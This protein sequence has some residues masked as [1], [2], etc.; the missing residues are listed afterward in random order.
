M[1]NP[2]NHN[3]FEICRADIAKLEDADL[4]LLVAELCRED[5]KRSQI[6]QTSV[7]DGGHQDAADGGIDI[8]IKVSNDFA[9]SVT[10]KNKLTAIQVKKPK[11]NPAAIK[12]E[13][14]PKGYLRPSLQELIKNN[15][16][17]IIV[18]SGDCVTDSELSKRIIA[19]KMATDNKLDVDFFDNGRLASWVSAY[20][21]MILWVKQKLGQA[22]TGWQAYGN[23]ANQRQK[24]N[25]VYLTDDTPNMIDDEK[26]QS[27]ITVSEGI[28]RIRQKLHK[29]QTNVRL[30]GLSGT[31]KTRLA[32]ALFDETIATDSLAKSE[33]IYGSIGD[34]LNPS[35]EQLAGQLVDK[36][37]R[38]ILI[39]DNAPPE[40]HKKLVN[41]SKRQ[42]SQLSILT[43]EY[44]VRD[45]DLSDEVNVFRLEPSSN[46]V[47]NKLIRQQFPSVNQNNADII[48]E[49]S[50][51]N[52]RIAIAIANTVK[53]SDNLTGL[54][55]GDLFKRL[56]DQQQGKDDSLF[57]S[58]KV[59]SLVYSFNGEMEESEQSHI[60]KL[61]ALA[62]KSYLAV[63]KDMAELKKR[64]L[65]QSRGVWRA[66][67]PPALAN[68]LAKEAV[69]SI[70]KDRLTKL[71]TESDEHLAR[72]FSRRLSYLYD[73]PE[74]IELVTPLMKAGGWIGDVRRLTDFGIGVFD[75]LAAVKPDLALAA[76]EKAVAEDSN[77]LTNHINHKNRFCRILQQIAY[78]EVY[79]SRCVQLLIEIASLED[80]H[81]KPA[82][83][84]LRRLFQPFL[85]GTLADENERLDIIKGLIQSSDQKKKEIGYTL[86][87]TTLG[88]RNFSYHQDAFGGRKRDFGYIPSQSWYSVFINYI[89]ELGVTE[90]EI[91]RKA[92]HIFAERF[93]NLWNEAVLRG[94]LEIAAINLHQSCGWHEGW[95]S[96]RQMIKLHNKDKSDF[97]LS[98]RKLEQKLKPT[99]LEQKIMAYLAGDNHQ[100]ADGESGGHKQRYTKL[101]RK[102]VNYGKNLGNDLA[103]F[104]KLLGLLTSETQ[105]ENNYQRNYLGQG[106]AQS[107]NTAQIWLALKTKLYQTEDNLR[108]PAVLRGLIQATRQ[109]DGNLG[110]TWLDDL[111]NDKIL[112]RWLP[113]CSYPL[114]L[115]GF[116]RLLVNLVR[117]DIDINHYQQIAYDP[118]IKTIDEK[119]LIALLRKISKREGGYIIVID[120]YRNYFNE[121]DK[122]LSNSSDEII[123]EV[124]EF[125]SNYP[126]EKRNNR[127]DYDLAGIAKHCLLMPQGENIVG[128]IIANMLPKLLDR[129][130]SD[131][132]YEL[133]FKMMAELQPKALL[134][135]FFGEQAD[136]VIK[137]NVLSI[138]FY[139]DLNCLN[140]I[141]DANLIAWCDENPQKHYPIIAKVIYAYSPPTQ[142]RPDA[143]WRPFFWHLLEKAPDL[144]QCLTLIKKAI[145]PAAYMG[146]LSAIL[147]RQLPL[148]QQLHGHANPVVAEWAK[149]IVIELQER[150]PKVKAWEIINAK[151]RDERFEF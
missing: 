3:I 30:V 94:E 102:L 59:L 146:P 122:K 106:L 128:K 50:G 22:V 65:L 96:I 109:Q 4:R 17:Y 103:L 126:Y 79:F 6:A 78:E 80:R 100:L 138:H 58:A 23:W 83:D 24:D 11:M 70:P 84:S 129:E 51:G 90:N 1:G 147:E 134:D 76:I 111:A 32:Q 33:V 44:D 19:M 71:L 52:Y 130:F 57:E 62:D 31:G 36:Q 55:D 137:K 13:M 139:L 132:D 99:N 56:F 88:L 131:K 9:S 43:I 107:F 104:N 64:D 63:Y 67:L 68:Y 40:L 97:F 115:R 46:D 144:A 92:R 66:I 114:N 89:L 14:K 110:E 47:I 27:K 135:S 39:V 125:L 117:E 38:A 7:T 12:K 108:N 118:I 86:L 77:F 37:A 54:P 74:V 101:N 142:E 148:Y 35:P 116:D 25:E 112:G 150:I 82:N 49:V 140:H 10:L 28:K 8:R 93:I 123:E 48:T 151:E 98:L 91:G 113:Y 127:T 2:Q 85:S 120:I 75:N 20:P 29:P 16:A 105:F 42:Q 81:S 95:V 87:K 119:K 136:E 18:S 69:E 15:G 41:I 121:I 21:P 5:C 141:A 73:L 45:D 133:L 34:E 145:N 149:T 26:S 53:K 124:G 60:A 143:E 61:A 72:S